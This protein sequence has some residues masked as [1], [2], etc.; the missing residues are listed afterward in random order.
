[1]KVVKIGQ[2]RNWEG[3]TMPVMTDAEKAGYDQTSTDIGQKTTGPDNAIDNNIAIF[4]GT[5]G[6]ILKDGGPPGGALSIASALAANAVYYNGQSVRVYEPLRTLSIVTMT[7][8]GSTVT[9]TTATAHGLVT[10]QAVLIIGADQ[11]E[12]NGT[13]IITVTSD[14]TFTFPITTTPV[15]PATGTISASTYPVFG[16]FLVRFY[17]GDP[18]YPL[19]P[20]V[21]YRLQQLET[22]EH[23]RVLLIKDQLTDFSA[24]CLTTDQITNLAPHANNCGLKV[25]NKD[26]DRFNY[27]H[28]NVI[29]VF[30]TVDEL[31]H[32]SIYTNSNLMSFGASPV[33]VTFDTT[34]FSAKNNPVTLV[35]NAFTLPLANIV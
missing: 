19:Y 32:E 25:F 14:K 34:P 35:N 23:P 21:I 22:P 7:R 29:K 9:C 6:K 33:T 18:E 2:T 26:T 5:S 10:P 24:M 12:Y 16:N 15:S 27:I 11:A 31:Q 28:K 4:S 17:T 1:M 8:S 3:Q 13:Y 20:G 30:A